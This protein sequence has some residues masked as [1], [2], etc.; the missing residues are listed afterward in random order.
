[1]QSG[2]SLHGLKCY[3]INNMKSNTQQKDTLGL[4]GKFRL[5]KTSSVTGEVISTTPYQKNLVMN[6]T[7]T[8]FNVIIDHLNNVS[9]YPLNISHLDIG[10]DDTAPAVSDT[11]LGAGVARSAKVTGVVSGS[12]LT[13]RFFFATG[14]LADDDYYE[15]G[16]FMNGGSGLGTGQIFSRALFGSVYTKGTNENTTI[17]YVISKQ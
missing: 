3:I 7:D 11:D 5:I 1:M 6:G 15:V 14:D 16:T 10:T 2:A 9:T 8:G 13:L 4:K 17:E 12:A